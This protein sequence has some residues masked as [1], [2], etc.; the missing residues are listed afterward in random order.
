MYVLPLGHSLSEVE[1]Q[2]IRLRQVYRLGW[3]S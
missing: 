2:V 1:V 3:I